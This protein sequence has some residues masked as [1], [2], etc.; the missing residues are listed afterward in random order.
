LQ[1]NELNSFSINNEILG[2]FKLQLKKDFESAGIDA[3]FTASLPDSLEL[4]TSAIEAALGP[5]ITNSSLL[6]SLLYR[7]DISETQL[8][9]AQRQDSTA[10]F[11]NVIATLILKRVLQKVILK[12]TH[13]KK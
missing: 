4:L 2:L 5:V 10:T 9:K 7:V 8:S 1:E 3:S 12:K 11:L 13:S 6:A